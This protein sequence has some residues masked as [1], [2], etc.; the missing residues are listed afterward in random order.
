MWAFSPPLFVDGSCGPV[1]PT[2]GEGVMGSPVRYRDSQR[3]RRGVLSRYWVK[4]NVEPCVN[5]FVKSFGLD[6]N[7]TYF[8]RLKI[9][10]NY[11]QSWV[12]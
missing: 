9:K 6:G 11:N 12:F 5:V 8:V 7:R 10:L 3:R 1:D 2:S 4:F